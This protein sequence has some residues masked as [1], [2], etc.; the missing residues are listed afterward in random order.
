MELKK[1]GALT[2]N[3]HVNPFMHESSLFMLRSLRFTTTPIQRH[4]SCSPRLNTGTQLPLH[5]GQCTIVKKL[6][7]GGF[8]TI[9]IADKAN[10][11]TKKA[12]KVSKILCIYGCGFITE[13]WLITIG[14]ESSIPVG[15]LDSRGTAQETEGQ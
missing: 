4:T 15:G 10:D 2:V 7:K 8:A 14:T 1:C 9:Y 6:L 5:N 12:L 3:G 11:K 13:V